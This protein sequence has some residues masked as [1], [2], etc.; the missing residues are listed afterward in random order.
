MSGRGKK[1]AAN[2]PIYGL[3]AG[4]CQDFIG[5]QIEVGRSDDL[6]QV[7][8]EGEFY[9]IAARAVLKSISHDVLIRLFAKASDSQRGVLTSLH[10]SP[11]ADELRLENHVLSIQERVDGF[12]R[13]ATRPSHLPAPPRPDFR[14]HSFSPPHQPA[15]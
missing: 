15:N 7:A 13:L 4:L 8:L 14:H 11:L 5:K 6:E 1:P 10:F 9:F 12:D 3:S 2:C